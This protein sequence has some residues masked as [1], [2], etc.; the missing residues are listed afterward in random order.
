MPKV[1]HESG[2]RRLLPYT[3]RHYGD[4]CKPEIWDGIS[5][6]SGFNGIQTST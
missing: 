1:S 4:Q 6:Q 2:M 3:A 5:I